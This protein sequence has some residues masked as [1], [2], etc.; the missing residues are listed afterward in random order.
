MRDLVRT[1]EIRYLGNVDPN[2]YFAL[3]TDPPDSEKPFDEKDQLVS[4]CAS[5]IEQLNEKYSSRGPS[6]FFHLHR[7][8]D[9]QRNESDLD[10]LGTQT[11]ETT[12]L[13]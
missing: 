1:L 5:L 8:P 13:Q 7:Y 2:L 4:Y 3:L 12:G 9:I 10:G 6:R 11:R